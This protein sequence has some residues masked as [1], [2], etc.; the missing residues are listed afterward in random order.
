M[1]ADRMPNA[2]AELTLEAGD[3]LFMPRGTAHLV[4]NFGRFLIQS[5]RPGWSNHFQ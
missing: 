2:L 3:M 4:Q 1:P 5:R